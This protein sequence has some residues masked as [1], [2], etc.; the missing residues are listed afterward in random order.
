MAVVTAIPATMVGA[1]QL[2]TTMQSGKSKAS[3]ITNNTWLACSLPVCIPKGLPS[4]CNVGNHCAMVAPLAPLHNGC[5]FAAKASG[6]VQM[7]GIHVRVATCLQ[8]G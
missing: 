6:S 1:L 7:P 3:H 2:L 8:L 4:L 5:K